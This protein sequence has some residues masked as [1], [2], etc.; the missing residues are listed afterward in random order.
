MIG[1]AY[2]I[3]TRPEG[4]RWM[5]A[6]C[7]CTSGPDQQYRTRCPWTEGEDSRVNH[8]L[9]DFAI[10]HGALTAHAGDSYTGDYRSSCG[11]CSIS[12]IS[13][14]QHWLSAKGLPTRS[15]LLQLLLGQVLTIE[16]V[17]PLCL[18]SETYTK[19]PKRTFTS[20]IRNGHSNMVQSFR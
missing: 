3:G 12:A 9:P 5:T 10:S 4:P 20:N 19:F 16:Q 13:L 17:H 2:H 7:C 11:A 8:A 14:A 1:C 18:S 15:R 6:Y